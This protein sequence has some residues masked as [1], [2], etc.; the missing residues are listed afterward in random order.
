MSTYLELFPNTFLED[1]VRNRCVPFIGAGF[2]KNADLPH[3]KNMPD[4]K[5]LAKSIEEDLPGSYDHYNPIDILSAFQY[6]YD[7]TKLIEKLSEFL[8]IDGVEPSETHKAFCRLNFEHVVTS[9]FDFLLE[10]GYEIVHKNCRPLLGEGQLSI[11]RRSG[12]VDLVK[13]HGDLNH[14]ESLVLVEEDYDLYL[15][16]FPL[17]ATYLT[18]ILIS[19]TAW[20]IGYSLEDPDFR[21]I[22]QLIGDRLGS[23]KRTAYTVLVNAPK[24]VVD[25]FERRN[26]K[27]INIPGSNKD[28]P[29]ILNDIFSELYDYWTQKLPEYSTITDEE[30]RR[31]LSLASNSLSRLCFFDVSIDYLSFYRSYIF[32]IAEA[33]GLTPVFLD[34]ILTPGDNISAKISSLFNRSSVIVLDLSMQNLSRQIGL[35]ADENLQNKNILIVSDVELSDL[36]I[37]ARYVRFYKRREEIF[38]DSANIA[39]LFDEWFFD[40]S[41]DLKPAFF[42]EP[43]N[44]L[45]KD[46]FRSAVVAAITL[47]E[48]TLR[49][50][51]EMDLE[52]SEKHKIY[53]M[54][55]LVEEAI[56]YQIIPA[57]MRQQLFSWLNV[58]NRIVHSNYAPRRST[59]LRIVEGIYDILNKN[60]T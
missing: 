48:Q 29:I 44:L 9:N 47:L 21:Q 34:D 23:L 6:E 22:W 18:N 17:L 11:N 46:E 43:R 58:R 55:K 5:E 59:A 60:A 52:S 36:P 50:E 39:E 49:D 24:H 56:Q 2:S 26:V 35:L 32:P 12:S 57:D 15:S 3:D 40:I 37:D 25:R 14:P 38:K 45:E 28:Y 16:H 53:S 51:L 33:Y 8:H 30:S 54:R 10:K 31:E 20:F 7:R 41:Q 42:N 13:F 4:W 1:I 19:N 27:V